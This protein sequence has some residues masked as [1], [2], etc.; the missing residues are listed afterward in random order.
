MNRILTFLVFLTFGLTQAQQLNCTVTVNTERLPNANQQVFKTLQTSLSEFVNKT[1]WT[2]T[3]LKQNERI[4]CSMYITLS[5]YSS[6]QFSGTIQIQSSRL[7]F[8]STYSSPVFNFNDKDFNFKY[9][10]YEPLLFNPSVYESNLVS[11]ISFYSYVILGMD[12]DTFQS[13]AGNQYFETAQNIANVAQQGGF[14]GWTQTDGLQNR[15]YLIN[16]MLS[17][18]FADLRQTSFLYHTGLDTMSDDLKGAKEKIKSSVVL[19]GKLNS[20]RPNAFLTRVFFDAKS[21]EIVSIFSGGPSI[22]VTDLTDVLNRVSPLNS[23]KWS[24]IKF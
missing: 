9:T 8:N 18:M 17:P 4:N 13:G 24:Q 6:D 19:I 15:Y 14:K 23:T 3:V 2:G 20:V 21:D 12:A 10:E 22:P 1:D 7:I 16:D 5:S 11:V